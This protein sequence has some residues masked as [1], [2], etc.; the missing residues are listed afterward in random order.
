MRRTYLMSLVGLMAMA[1]SCKTP[2]QAQSETKSI[3]L[4]SATVAIAESLLETFFNVS[5]ETQMA[6][7]YESI[8]HYGEHFGDVNDAEVKANSA[9]INSPVTK[10]FQLPLKIKLNS[11][12]DT[13]S[14]DYV[15]GSP[16]SDNLLALMIDKA[17]DIRNSIEERGKPDS[18]PNYLVDALASY[19][20]YLLI[21]SLSLSI[22]QERVRSAE[23]SGNLG[24]GVIV[25]LR[26]SV[27]TSAKE[28][29]AYIKKLN[30]PIFEAYARQKLLTYTMKSAAMSVDFGFESRVTYTYCA[31]GTS[32]PELCGARS[33][34]SCDTELNAD[35]VKKAQEEAKA[36][37]TQA[38]HEQKLITAARKTLFAI[39]LVQFA[40]KMEARASAQ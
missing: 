23:S 33:S 12:Q 26:D 29:A 39:D 22:L 18:G 9:A 32:G 14:R 17:N 30:G 27:I 25:K 5:L 13:L 28:S 10:D 16:D 15:A 36:N 38:G 2:Q 4:V 37:F 20:S 34:T 3:A 8:I 35:C 24:P 40:D 1:N 31:Q 21:S 19:Q 6:T 11:L 7:I